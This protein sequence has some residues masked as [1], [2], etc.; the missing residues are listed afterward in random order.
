MKRFKTKNLNRVLPKIK[1]IKVVNPTFNLLLKRKNYI[2]DIFKNKLFFI[3]QLKYKLGL[4]TVA[5]YNALKKTNSLDFFKAYFRRLDIILFNL[6]FFHSLYGA[7]QAIL[8][9]NIYINGQVITKHSFLLESGDIVKSLRPTSFF[10]RS[11]YKLTAYNGEYYEINYKILT[12][13]ILSSSLSQF[14]FIK[15]LVLYYWVSN[16]N[17]FI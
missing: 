7:R 1:K 11:K 12:C 17:R 9:K 10:V 6:G 3:R 2:K 13:V 16:K 14:D 8:H 15:K 5:Y 4:P